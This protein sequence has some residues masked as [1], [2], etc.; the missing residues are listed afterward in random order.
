MLKT[1]YCYNQY[2]MDIAWTRIEGNDNTI[3][4]AKVVSVSTSCSR[5]HILTP[6]SCSYNL[7]T[8]C[9]TDSFCYDLS[10]VLSKRHTLILSNTRELNRVPKYKISILYTN[11]WWSV[12]HSFSSTL[13]TMYLFWGQHILTMPYDIIFFRT[14]YI[15]P[16]CHMSMW[17]WHVTCDDIT[18][19]LR[20]PWSIIKNKKRENQI[21]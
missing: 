9:I 3:G 5:C 11:Y 4:C 17:P 15:V 7:F 8:S 19:C 6:S 2:L 21:N 1:G 16:L 10:Y 14:F 18:F 12:L 20:H 13:I